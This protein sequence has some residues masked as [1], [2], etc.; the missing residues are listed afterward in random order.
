MSSDDDQSGWFSPAGPSNS[1]DDGEDTRHLEAVPSGP[2]SSD[3][4]WFELPDLPDS[5]PVVSQTAPVRADSRAR[6]KALFVGIVA[7]VLMVIGGGAWMLSSLM[8]GPETSASPTLALPP[9]PAPASGDGGAVAESECEISESATAVSGNGRGDTKS[10]AGA[11]LA[12]QHAYYVARDADEV[13]PLLTEDS[14]ITN[15]DA[16]QKGIDSVARGTTHCLRIVSDGDDSA[17]VELTETAPDGT[18]TTYHQR[19]KTVRD[20]GQVRIVSIEDHSEGV[21]E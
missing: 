6:A 9:T 2:A 18:E 3:E 20:S 15:L 7:V 1:A 13:K 5:E 11:V 4:Q 8:S 21:R 12:F 17:V 19:V 16:L 10:V 14:K